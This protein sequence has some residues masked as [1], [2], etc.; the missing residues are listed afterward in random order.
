M[1]L[2]LKN[3]TALVLASSKGIGKAISYNL[4][5]NGAN[6]F[7]V[8]RSQNLLEEIKNNLTTKYGV[9]VHV[10]STDLGVA[11]SRDELI[12]DIK[13]NVSKLDIIVHNTGGPKVGPV[14]NLDETD[15]QDSFNRLFLPVI[16]INKEFLPSM[17]DNKFGRIL[18]I[19]SLSVIEPIENM[20]LSNT[21]RSAITAMLKTLANEVA[22][23]NITVNCIAP[24][25]VETDRT[26]ELLESRIKLSKQSK[27][28]YLQ[29]HLSTI[30]A[31]RM[32]NVDELASLATFLCSE[33]ASYITGSTICVDGGK[34]KSTY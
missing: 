28:E 27:E 6:L 26:K 20:A 22:S 7:L 31:K 23:F 3:K 5:A 13:K 11:E 8:S 14:L 9:T 21:I 4:A 1:D 17:I 30:P 33:Q 2:K 34:R 16:H 18:C 24:G 29:T 15:F 12:K 10:K 19:T 25:W 32:G